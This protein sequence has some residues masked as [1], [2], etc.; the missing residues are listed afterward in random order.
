MNKRWQV[1]VACL[2]IFAAGAL[3]GGVVAL[4]YSRG[5]G[6]WH[7]ME[8]GHIA[9]Q[10]LDRWTTELNL[11][12]EQQE[13]IR[14]ILLRGDDEMRKLRSE[15]FRNGTAVME[16]MQAEVSA[17]LSPDQRTKLE[18]LQERF[19]RRLNTRKP[20][21]GRGEGRPSKGAGESPP[22]PPPES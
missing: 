12:P 22:A 13:K 19:R 7:A 2:G 4:R 16:R 10:L 20:R 1:F 18:E 5:S 3:C 21:E 9:K 15:S 14:P 6:G 8:R 11:T 17:V